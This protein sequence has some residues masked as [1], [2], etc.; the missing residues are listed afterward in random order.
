METLIERIDNERNE[1]LDALYWEHQED[2]KQ[3]FIEEERMAEAQLGL[4]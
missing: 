4:I 1:Q 3:L 2:E